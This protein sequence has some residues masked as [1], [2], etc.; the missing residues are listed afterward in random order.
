VTPSYQLTPERR[1]IGGCVVLVLA[2]IVLVS[3]GCSKLKNENSNAG[4]GGGGHTSTSADNSNTGQ[5]SPSS[6]GEG[7]PTTWEANAT[8][9][10]GKDGETFT[11]VCSPGGTAHS[12][13]GS[14]VYTAD[15]SICTAAVHSGLIT[16]QQGGAVTIELRPGRT[17]YGC[18]ERNGVTTSSYGS[19]QHS[20]VFKTPNTEA[21]LREAD[22][23]TPVLWN[24]S[25]SMVGSETGKT[26]KFKCPPGGKESNVWGTDIYTADSSICNAAVHAGK[27]T[28]ESGSSV[29]IEIRPGES[30]YQG[31]TRNG[32]KTNDYPAYGR[33]FV[34]K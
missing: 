9:L 30:S 14:D 2:A 23:Q 5:S 29:T 20:F 17:I 6:A 3:A 11:L 26:Y 33:S 4:T 31:T 27:L 15:S 19:Y 25:A 10:N 7:K 16:Y 21:I 32:I 18:S 34:V 1:I 28:M 24:S 8:S 22:E 13:W 12:V